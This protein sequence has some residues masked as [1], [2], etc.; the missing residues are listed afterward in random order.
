MPRVDPV[1]FLE[2]IL[3]AATFPSGDAVLTEWRAID[4]NSFDDLGVGVA[5]EQHG[6]DGI[7]EFFG[8]PRDPAVALAAGC[9]RIIILYRYD[10]GL[11]CLGGHGMRGELVNE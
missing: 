11:L 8:E 9:E 4:G 5:V 6:V 3:V 7:A 10:N 2:P 1:L